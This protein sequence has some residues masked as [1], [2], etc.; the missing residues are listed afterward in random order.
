MEIKKV[1]INK[2]SKQKYVIIPKK[3]DIVEGDYVELKKVEGG[4]NGRR[5]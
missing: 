1:L 3:S 5:R 4:Q 2:V